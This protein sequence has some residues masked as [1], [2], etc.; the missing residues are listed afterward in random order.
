VLGKLGKI[1]ITFCEMRERKKNCLLAY[2]NVVVHIHS[3]ETGKLFKKKKLKIV[4]NLLLFELFLKLLATIDFFKF[5][6][7]K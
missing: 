5:T 4:W 7:K 3:D 1:K 6:N 2:E